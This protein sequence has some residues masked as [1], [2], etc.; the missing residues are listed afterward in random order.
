MISEGVTAGVQYG[1][2]KVN[3][4][5]VSVPVL[6]E[7]STSIPAQFFHRSQVRDDGFLVS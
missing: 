4:F 6:S 1:S 2:P 7:H 5:C 3:L